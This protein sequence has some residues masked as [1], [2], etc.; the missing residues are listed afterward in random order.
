MVNV[1]PN[2][3]FVLSPT[4]VSSGACSQKMSQ[5][6]PKIVDLVAKTKFGDRKS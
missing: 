2:F 6:G 5:I 4:Y 1:L 3:F